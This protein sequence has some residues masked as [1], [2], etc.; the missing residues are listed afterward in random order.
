MPTKG[1]SILWD[2]GTVIEPAIRV[3]AQRT[4][5]VQIAGQREAR[6]ITGPFGTIVPV[7]ANPR[8]AYPDLKRPERTPVEVS[9]RTK[10]SRPP[11]DDESTKRQRPPRYP[12]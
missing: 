12:K 7:L 1:G 11:G 9:S 10:A 5:R 2:D 4:Y 6:E 8:A 3:V